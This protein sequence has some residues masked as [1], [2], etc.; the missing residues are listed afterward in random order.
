MVK[1]LS[2]ENCTSNPGETSN[3]G[4]HLA[5]ASPQEFLILRVPWWVHPRETGPRLD[6]ACEVEGPVEGSAMQRAWLR[7]PIFM[8]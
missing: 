4:Q 7:S 2:Q 1:H 6:G 8:P 5:S 3:G